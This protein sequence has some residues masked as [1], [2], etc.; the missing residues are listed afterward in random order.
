[1]WWGFMQW[2]VVCEADRDEGVAPTNTQWSLKQLLG[3]TKQFV[4]FADSTN[5]GKK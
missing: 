2:L 1:M 3:S 4:A 5:A